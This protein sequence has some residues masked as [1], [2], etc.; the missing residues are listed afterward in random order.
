MNLFRGWPALSQWDHNSTSK[1]GCPTLVAAFGDRVGAA[2]QGP[3]Y[4]A[5]ATLAA[6]ISRGRVPQASLH[7]LPGSYELRD[8][9]HP[10]VGLLYEGKL[11][12]DKTYGHAG[13][14]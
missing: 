11:T 2:S 6:H 3:A 9:D 12:I 13:G 14:P 4:P 8:I 10:G 5:E 1:L 7:C